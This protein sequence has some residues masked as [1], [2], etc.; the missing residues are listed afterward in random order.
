MNTQQNIIHLY[1]STSLPCGLW[2]CGAPAYEALMEP[3]LRAP[4]LWQAVPICPRCS[5]RLDKRL[6]SVDDILE[7]DATQPDEETAQNH[8]SP[9]L[10][11]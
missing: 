9:A 6:T 10:S 11:S 1:L 3:D 8:P 2:R 5:A 4:G 7:A